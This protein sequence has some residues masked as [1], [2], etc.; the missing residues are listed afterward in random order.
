MDIN[1]LTE[2]AIIDPL[3]YGETTTAPVDYP[4][5]TR[6]GWVNAK[7]DRWSMLSDAYSGS[8]GFASARY[9]VP[10]RREEKASFNLRK[11]KAGYANDYKSIINALISPIFRKDA[12]RAWEDATD[13]QEE[14]L[15]KFMGHASKNGNDYA[16]NMKTISRNSR[17]Y[18][19]GYIMVGAPVNTAENMAELNDLERMPYLV[20]LTPGQVVE[21][22][23]STDGILE[24]FAWAGTRIIKDKEVEIVYEYTPET[25]RPKKMSARTLTPLQK[26]R[27]TP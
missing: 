20:H 24:L 15:S 23:M 14:I 26:E 16:T 18:D 22:K 3:T 13:V 12:V 19:T 10:H 11:I 1:D 8:G 5:K 25:Y 27:P 6:V 9:L 2:G 7:A 4:A 21:Q 17:K